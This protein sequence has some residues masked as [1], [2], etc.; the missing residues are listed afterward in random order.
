MLAA[1][2]TMD[3]KAVNGINELNEYVEVLKNQLTKKVDSKAFDN[4]VEAQ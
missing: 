3:K 2:R 1:M 4:L